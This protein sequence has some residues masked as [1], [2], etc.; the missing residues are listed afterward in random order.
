VRAKVVGKL[1]KQIKII[2][3]EQHIN[4]KRKIIF[5]QSRKLERDEKEAPG[6]FGT[7]FRRD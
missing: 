1:K 2:P 4:G 5:L 6:F 7:F 3:R